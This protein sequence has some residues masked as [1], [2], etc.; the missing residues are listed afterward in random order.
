MRHKQRL[1]GSGRR[2]GRGKPWRSRADGLFSSTESTICVWRLATTFRSTRYWRA[3]ES[4]CLCRFGT[5]AQQL[6][7]D[8]PFPFASCACHGLLLSPSLFWKAHRR[9]PRRALY[10]SSRRLR[11]PC[12][13]VGGGDRHLTQPPPATV[14][15]TSAAPLSR[16]PLLVASWWRR[17]T[18]RWWTPVVTVT[19][20][21]RRRR[22]RR[23]ALS[24]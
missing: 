17:W 4:Q 8:S 14:S 12:R 3:L 24:S 2:S 6:E 7:V 11:R 10:F 22:P 18:L 20:A 15:R 5:W 9:L 23:S 21:S 1:V 13:G 19:V 16:W